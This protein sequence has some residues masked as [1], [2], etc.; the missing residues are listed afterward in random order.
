MGT[1]MNPVFRFAQASFIL[2]FVL[3]AACA[4]LA[5]KPA[6]FGWPV[7]SVL[8]ADASGMVQENR[9]Q[10]SF[11]I[12][13]LVFEEKEDS[14]DVG[15]LSVRVIRDQA[16]YYYITS[17]GFRHVYVFGTGDGALVLENKILVS[18]KGLQSPAFNARPPY[19]QLLS[20]GEK[21][22]LLS[23]SGIQEGGR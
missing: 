18:E 12:K 9:Y 23:R 4:P 14:M 15:G 13:P 3:L 17:S 11:S 19:V 8:K 10:V 20:A 2:P 16:G 21:P 7:E 6:D 22:R 1:I 5:L